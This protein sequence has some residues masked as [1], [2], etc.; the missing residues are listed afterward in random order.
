MG[1]ILIRNVSDKAIDSFKFRARMNGTSL[2]H[3]VR[4]L[5]ESRA[6]L[7]P[8]ERVQLS[9][10]LRSKTVGVAKPLTAEERREGLE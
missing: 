1:Q 5:I 7:T 8:D 6:T 3:E 9:R 4:Q 10:K 2:E